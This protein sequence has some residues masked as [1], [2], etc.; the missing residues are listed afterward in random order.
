MSRLIGSVADFLF[1]GPRLHRFGE[2]FVTFAGGQWTGPHKGERGGTYWIRPDGEKS[3]EPP[4]DQG[5]AS[6]TST[7]A[8]PTEPQASP[9]RIDTREKFDRAKSN[10]AKARTVAVE[11]NS[12]PAAEFNRLG[13]LAFDHPSV[14]KVY[15]LLGNEP[16]ENDVNARIRWHYSLADAAEKAVEKYK[17]ITSEELERINFKRASK[18][19]YSDDLEKVVKDRAAVLLSL[20]KVIVSARKAGGALVTYQEMKRFIKQDLAKPKPKQPRQ[21][22]EFFAEFQRFANE[23]RGPFQGERGGTYWIAPSGE[24]DYEGPAKDGGSG[25]SSATA[26]DDGKRWESKRA[27]LAE[28]ATKLASPS[29]ARA[30]AESSGRDTAD[31][32]AKAFAASPPSPSDIQETGAAWDASASK[33]GLPSRAAGA[34]KSAITSTLAFADSGGIWGGIK[35]IAGVIFKLGKA[36][37]GPA[38][39]ALGRMAI[40]LLKPAGRML[41]GVGVHVGGIAAGAALVTASAFLPAAVPFAAKAVIA[42]GGAIAARLLIGKTAKIGGRLIDPM[43]RPPKQN[44]E[45]FGDWQ[46][47]KGERGGAGWVNPSTG[48]VRYQDDKPDDTVTSNNPEGIPS[49]QASATR[50]EKKSSSGPY[51]GGRE[52]VDI[53]PFDDPETMSKSFGDALA[54]AP[55]LDDVEQQQRRATVQAVVGKLTDRAI[56]HLSHTVKIVTACN[57]LGDIGEQLTEMTGEK[58]EQ[59]DVVGGLWSPRKGRL[60]VD[61]GFEDESYTDEEQ[62]MTAKGIFAHEIGHALDTVNGG[63]SLSKTDDFQECFDSEIKNGQLTEYATTDEQEGFAEFARLLYGSDISREEIAA[64]FPQTLAFFKEKGLA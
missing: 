35:A 38:I 2:D 33:A 22:A 30:V 18:E 32:A 36:L 34:I 12:K 4:A 60:V 8:K 40:A 39:K 47:Y 17:L 21:M 1:S 5:A 50:A 15:D 26:T 62:R 28:L 37:I 43:Q 61:G 29:K 48:E 59:D 53:E 7:A 23:W 31:Q 19:G 44:A 42:I 51:V 11:L 46:P 6:D 52:Q 57:G 3:Y 63:Y 54:S 56:D 16:P 25:T 14:R 58:L 45:L 20:R 55:G 9:R 64:K 27:E 41:A 13:G 10:L 24:K 49:K